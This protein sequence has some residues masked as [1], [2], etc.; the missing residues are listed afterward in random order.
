MN[1]FLTVF[2]K[3][4]SIYILKYVLLCTVIVLLIEG[5]KVLLDFE[6]VISNKLEESCFN[7]LIWSCFGAVFFSP[8]LEET[9]FRLS[10]RRNVYFPA[11]I[12]ICLVFLLSSTYIYTQVSWILFM[13]LILVNQY[14][15]NFSHRLI[16]ILLICFS[17]ISFVLI[18]FDNYDKRELH[19][20]N[21][22]EIVLLFMHQFILCIILT[23]VRLE[24]CFINSLIIHSL[25]NL[26]ILTFALIFN[27]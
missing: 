9:A 8:L 15:K 5:M 20:L 24:T 25:Y 3:K 13:L 21:P 2:Q 4:N 1:C 12:I 18:H 16:E 10:L 26:I 7:N 19:S 6:Q 14:K 23:K 27:Y 11:S 22:F 17:V